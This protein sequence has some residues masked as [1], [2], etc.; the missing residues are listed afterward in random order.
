MKK[1]KK[2]NS[3]FSLSGFEEIS[4]P[5]RRNTSKDMAT[6]SSNGKLTIPGAAVD[7]TLSP[8]KFYR[9]LFNP[10]KKKLAIIFINELEGPEIPPNIYK[11][12]WFP[13]GKTAYLDL[14]TSLR[15]WG[16]EC[17]AKCLLPMRWEKHGRENIL[18]FDLADKI[19]PAITESDIMQILK[20]EISRKKEARFF[21]FEY[22]L[23]LKNGKPF[24]LDVAIPAIKMG[25]VIKSPTRFLPIS[26]IQ[27]QR[28]L[29][30]IGWLHLV[31]TSKEILDR[32]S[33]IV[34]AIILIFHA[35][36]ERRGIDLD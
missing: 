35:F 24:I 18:V 20:K 10:E 30:E 8:A 15:D 27:I 11:I 26:I 9:A 29:A 28:H 2:R 34:E 22:A 5:R 3:E 13:N 33:Q 1:S 36:C 16:Y 6:L 14:K 17:H 21:Q 7:E 23:K 12:W 32:P 19:K 25:V 4:R 31:F